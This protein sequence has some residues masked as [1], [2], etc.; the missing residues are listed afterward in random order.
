MTILL[1]LQFQ[2]LAIRPFRDA[3]SGG[4]YHLG[5][6]RHDGVYLGR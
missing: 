4:V 1:R 2:R 6:E 5:G 3:Y